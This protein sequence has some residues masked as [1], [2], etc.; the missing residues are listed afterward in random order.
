MALKLSIGAMLLRLTVV[1]THRIIIYTTLAITE[2]YCTF[3]FFIFVFQCQAPEFFWTKYTGGKGRCLDPQ[4]AVIAAYA[5][6]AIACV[7][8]WTFAI[9]P[10]FLVWNLQINSRRRAAVA[11]VL[12][13]GAIASA[14]T[15]IR[16]PYIHTYKDQADFLYATTDVVIWSCAETGLGIAACSLATLRPLFRAFFS[17]SHLM[18]DSSSHK[19]TSNEWPTGAWP[20]QRSKSQGGTEEYG[21]RSDIRTSRDAVTIIES[22][23]DLDLEGR[24]PGGM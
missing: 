5:Y 4:I 21:L 3:F 15:I 9:I 12:S 13:M 17:R 2:V 6:S 22:D 19:L 1:T 8:D 10:V 7:G 18:G 11:I 14:A 23:R 24:E 16:I 20:Y